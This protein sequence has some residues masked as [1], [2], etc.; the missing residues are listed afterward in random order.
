[1]SGGDPVVDV[2][3]ADGV[4]PVAQVHVLAVEEQPVREA[5]DRVERVVAH[6]EARPG[7]HLDR[8]VALPGGLLHPS[9][10]GSPSEHPGQRQL[11]PARA[12][13]RHVAEMHAGHV[14]HRRS[15]RDGVGRCGRHELDQGL[16]GDGEVGV[17]ERDPVAARRGLEYAEVASASEPD[18]AP[19]PYEEGVESFRRRLQVVGGGV[20]DEHDV[21][22]VRGRRDVAG[23]DRFGGVEADG[24]DGD[25]HGRAPRASVTTSR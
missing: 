8:L 7:R 13:P 10:R 2:D 4:E 1:M 24:D 12:D 23:L 21:D 5:A 3:P 16:G 17:D 9:L 6:D 25:G 19:R 20:V 22:R 11:V 18:V 15:D 14:L